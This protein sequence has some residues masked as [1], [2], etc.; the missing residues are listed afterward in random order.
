MWRRAIEPSD[1]RKRHMGERGSPVS[2]RRS[3]LISSSSLHS[4][5]RSAARLQPSSS[6]NTPRTTPSNTQGHRHARRYSS[7]SVRWSCLSRAVEDVAD[8]A[9]LSTFRSA[10]TP[11]GTCL[12]EAE[13]LSL[14]SEASRLKRDPKVSRPIA[15]LLSKNML[16][17][18]FEADVVSLAASR[19]HPAAAT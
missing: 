3:S 12:L 11:P 5:Y 16:S 1:A 9:G 7:I 19:Y 4:F 18:L 8:T 2:H 17:L 6:D 13:D 10:L 14:G 15:L